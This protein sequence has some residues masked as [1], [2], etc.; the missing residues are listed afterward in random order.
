[1]PFILTLGTELQKAKS[2]CFN[3]VVYYWLIIIWVLQ[4]LTQNL[5]VYGYFRCSTNLQDE[6]RQIKALKDAKLDFKKQN[7]N[8]LQ[9][10]IENEICEYAVDF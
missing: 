2:L 3:P 6:E 1:M 5:T 7:V 4:K 10:S 8:I 9:E